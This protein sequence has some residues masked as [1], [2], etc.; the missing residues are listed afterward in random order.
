MTYQILIAGSGFAGTWAA[1]SAARAAAL[2][3]RE[4]D[5][6]IT[7]IS[8]EP[9][10]VMRPRL[11][12]AAIEGMDP[13]IAPLLAAVG[14]RH[15]AA[16]VEVIDAEARTVTV[17][18]AD[19][20]WETLAYDRFILA[21]GSVLNQPPI[22]GLPEHAFNVDQIADARRLAAHLAGLATRPV[23]AGRG[24]VVIGGGGFTGIETAAEMPRR[25]RAIL[26]EDA[27]IRVVIVEREAAIGPELGANP[28]PVIAAELAAK[29]IEVRTGVGIAGITP[30]HVVLSDGTRV[31]TETLVWT[32]GAR[33]HPLAAQV[34][35]ERDALGRVATDPYLRALGHGPAGVGIYVTGDVAHVAADEAGNLAMMSCQHALIL[36]R[37]AGHNAV[38]DLLG[39]PLHAYSQP[40]YATCLDL[41]HDAAMVSQGWDRQ[42]V[43]T[44]A[45][46]KAQKVEINTVWIYPP[47][48]TRE[49][50]FAAARPDFAI[51]AAG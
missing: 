32:A 42:V 28:R 19:G 49:A 25:L 51:P 40:T 36:G 47:A 22:A 23:S 29:G 31:D 20:A 46:A 6:A 33:A 24:T 34:P 44:G 16:K 43:L 41:G 3:G 18:S 21:T 26:G 5:I 1:L 11:Y 45:A 14:V 9:R 8:P 27:P 15:R 13:D 2:A 37:V 4:D 35:G 50:A 12:E 48:P 10:L 38:Q 7:V 17:A 39:L 30:D